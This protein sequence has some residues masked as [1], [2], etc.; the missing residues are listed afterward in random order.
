[1]MAVVDAIMPSSKLVRV[2]VSFLKV[3][4]VIRSRPQNVVEQ[5][6]SH[7]V[8]QLL[9]LCLHLKFSTGLKVTFDI[10]SIYVL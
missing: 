9:K 3:A 1:M 10:I 7:I 6:L 4:E 5:V 2:P 8:C